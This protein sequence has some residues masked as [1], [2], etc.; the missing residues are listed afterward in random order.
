MAKESYEAIVIGA[1]PG[2]YVAAIRLGQLGIKTLCVEKEYWGGVCLN[3]GCIPSKALI[4]ASG[5]AHKVRNSA[6]IGI[7]VEGLKV[8]VAK[9]QEWKDGIVKKLT[10]GVKG[11]VKGN[12]AD[13]AFGAAK[14]VSKNEV[15]VT[16]PD[17][18][19]TTYEATKGIIVA[20]G[21]QIINIPGFEPD[22]ETIVDA[23]A[24]V[25]LQSAPESMMI[26]GGGVIGM[27]LGMVYQKL[28]T[29]LTV[30]ELMDQILPGTDKDLVKVVEKHFT[31]GDNPATVLTK[32]KAK[33]VTVKEGNAK[34]VVETDGKDQTFEVEKLLVCVG[35]RPNSKGLGLEEVGVKLDDRGHIEVNDKFETNVPGIYAIGDV[36]GLPYLA[37][38]ASKE[39]EIAAE[40]I[41][42]HK[43]ALN[44]VV[45]MPAAIFTDPEI[46]TVGLTETA[47]KKAGKK[48]EVGKFPFAASGRAMAVQETDGFI[49]VLTDPENDS[50]V[51]GMA[52][53]GPEASDLISEG[54]LAMEMHAY[55][56]DVALTVHP[57]PTLGEG[58]ME[59]FKASMGEAIHVMNR[60]K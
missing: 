4:A 48:Y 31:K 54:A 1:G 44:D 60:K 39:G 17:G 14:L 57:H 10:S 56:E 46:A 34:V 59:A 20:T 28:G 41:A 32:S 25:S 58:V 40:V 35:F 11:L 8:D 45:A 50:K 2:G 43:G 9:M 51:L 27:E 24:A 29:K 22:G 13:V 23:R 21:A 33:S 7:E 47:A 52:I 6:H 19:T 53:V 49:K 42:G 15:E 26:V 18:K 3:W 36:T 5:L 16:D 37:H 12:G 38:K 55:A 30:V